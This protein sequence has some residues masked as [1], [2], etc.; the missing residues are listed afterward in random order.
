MNEVT[1]Q[2]P[3]TL[4]QNLE[5]L[6]E[7]EAVPLTQYIVY[8]LT[9]QMSEGYTVRVVPEEDVVGQKASFDS[10][11]KKWGR[12]PHS[13]ADRILDRRETVPP[14]AD[15]TPEVVS[16]LKGRIKNKPC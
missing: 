3:K 2:L 15:L 13:E 4:Y 14:E 1:L 11:L 10:L 16:R 9:R 6:A 7:R 8:I 12:I 5:I